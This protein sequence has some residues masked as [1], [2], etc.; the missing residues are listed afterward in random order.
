MN[1]FRKFLPLALLTP[2]AL[3]LDQWT[4]YLAVKNLTHALTSGGMHFYSPM[5][6][7]A[8]RAEPVHVTSFWDFRYAENTGAAFSFMAG[9]NDSLRVPFFYLV[10]VAAT[11]LILYFYVKSGP[12]HLLRRLALAMVLGGAFGNT[13]DRVVHGYVID[14]ILWHA[15]PHEWPVFNVADSFVCVGVFLLLTEGWFVKRLEGGAVTASK[16]AS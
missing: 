8:Y 15:G 6:L 9:T 13:L 1:G 4:K 16:A 3:A 12:E 11:A 5:R 2:L 7:L 14:F 10:A